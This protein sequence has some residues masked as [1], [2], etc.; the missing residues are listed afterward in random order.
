[1]SAPPRTLGP[2]EIVRR[3]GGGGMG[4]TF[5]AVKRGPGGFE[6][7]VCLKRVLPEH[8]GDETFVRFFLEEARIAATL[9]HSNIVGVV[10]FGEADGAYFMAL[11]LLDGT[12]LGQILRRTPGRRVPPPLV[13]LIGADLAH[14]L[15]YAHGR[16]RAGEASGI[17]HRDLSASNVLVSYAG[18][19]KLSDFGL[20]KVM[21]AGHA[22]MSGTV[23]GKVPY[24]SPEQV[25]ADRMDARSDLFSL[26]IV[27]HEALTGA[28]PFDGE[29]FGET[30]A[31]ILNGRRPPLA[32]L[33]QAAPRELVAVIDQLLEI[34]PDRRPPTAAALVDA[35][36][37]LTPAPSARREL[38]G[39]ALRARPKQTIG[40][41]PVDDTGP[42]DGPAYSLKAA[43]VS[44]S[45]LRSVA[46]GAGI[47]LVIAAVGGLGLFAYR[48]WGGATREPVATTAPAHPPPTPAL[49]APV[50][51][52]SSPPATDLAVPPSPA[53]APPEAPS[54]H[55]VPAPPASPAPDPAPPRV[56]PA[57]AS[58][59]VTDDR[60]TVT[61]SAVP[62]GR[63]WIDGRLVG[64]APARATLAPGAHTIA[65]GAGDRP[66]ARTTI[67]VAPGERRSVTLRLQ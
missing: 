42:R 12:D 25:K 56:P 62:W 1:M 7:R 41:L 65:A 40:V 4:E 61:V 47:G 46:R 3:L 53:P 11:E 60:A 27:L 21:T 51:P 17:L 48:E 18:E 6:Q 33:A 67:R 59:E 2:Y 38:G 31:K 54:P 34:D 55:A 37:P 24:M 64:N 32:E 44:L 45:T 36:A 22:T 58:P 39:I 30:M 52:V 63:V 29:T 35:L 26:G 14:A 9:R 19:V 15:E 13:A 5:L 16:T 20:A 49:P 43:P 28:R 23:R 66:T 57:P 10:D 8:E 50:A